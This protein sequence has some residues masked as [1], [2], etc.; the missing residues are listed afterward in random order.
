MSVKPEASAVTSRASAHEVRPENHLPQVPASTLNRVWDNVVPTYSDDPR[1]TMAKVSIWL[2]WFAAILALILMAIPP[3]NLHLVAVITPLAAIAI[4]S[5]VVLY[6]V[7][8]QRFP[9]RSFIIMSLLDTALIAV[10]VAFSGAATSRYQLLFFLI[11]V[12]ASYFYSVTD[13]ALITAVTVATLVAP[14]IYGARSP[15]WI[16]PMIACEAGV[17]VLVAAVTKETNLRVD[18]ERER[19]DQLEAETNRLYQDEVERRTSLQQKTRQL[20][21]ILD[22]GNA[23]RLQLGLDALLEKIASA[24]G[25][26]AGFR[27]VVVRLF[28]PVTG[29]AL[30]KAAY[31]IDW[32]IVQLPT[33][34][35]LIASLMDLKHQ[36]SRSY[37]V[38]VEPEALDHPDTRP[39]L[40]V[41]PDASPIT[42]EWTPQHSLIVPL[43]TRE[44]GL[45]GI[46]SIDEPLDGKIP[47]IDTIQTLEIFANLAATAIDNAN[48]LVEAGQAQ[49]LR[50]LDRLKS[51]FL[52]TVSHD[53]RTPLTVIKG[54]IDLLERDTERMEAIQAKL[55]RSIGRN[56]QRLM[57]MVEQ[58][59]EMIQ[60]QDGRVVLHRQLVDIR[61]IVSD[62]ADAMTV[63]AASRGQLIT[64]ASPSDAT[65]VFV[66]RSRIQQVMTNLVGNACKYGP[67]DEHIEV[68][69]EDSGQEVLVRVHDKGAGI[70]PDDQK[71]IFEKFYRSETMSARA[72]GSGLGLA[73]CQ[74]IIA[75]HGGRIWVD[76][77]PGEG[78]TFTYT[79]PKATIDG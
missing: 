41:R 21:S 79:V 65:P 18:R 3:T 42:G 20:E 35:Q 32:H 1:L 47:S 70:A 50:E 28:D 77:Q 2:H 31:G 61:D 55:V 24:I 23:F 17:M 63:A 68:A 7:P 51:E 11:V 66:D 19:R 14:L 9:A 44:H 12:F 38:Q 62:T 45:I 69:I 56:T 8:W 46:I 16:V 60:L 30:C 59:L 58:L 40:Y 54:S 78:T 22:T 5:T 67:E 25:E 76:S 57:D 73:I 33:P 64:V 4:L 37:L 36:V 6:R 15:S 52:A 26:T 13:A 75:L 72:E 27:A 53:L 49:A 71:R 74:S 34:P 10:G 48:L 43:E 29:E 39:Y